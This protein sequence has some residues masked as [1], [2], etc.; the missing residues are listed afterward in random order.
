MPR[1]EH[2]SK[3]STYF[4]LV[5]FDK[6]LDCLLDDMSGYVAVGDVNTKKF[7]ILR[8]NSMLEMARNLPHDGVYL[9]HLIFSNKFNLLFHFLKDIVRIEGVKGKDLTNF[10]TFTTK[11]YTIRN[12][13]LIC[14]TYK[15]ESIEEAINFITSIMETIDI[16][17]CEYSYVHIANLLMRQQ[18]PLAFNDM[19]QLTRKC[20]SFDLD[21]YNYITKATSKPNTA[22]CRKDYFVD[23]V[24]SYDMKSAYPYLYSTLSF[25]MGRPKKVDNPIEEQLIGKFDAEIVLKHYPVPKYRGIPD[26]ESKTMTVNELSFI[27]L[28]ENYDDTEIEKINSLWIYNS[29]SKLP[30]SYRC[31]LEE[32][33]NMKEKTK[34]KNIKTGL[35]G[36]IGKACQKIKYLTKLDTNGNKIEQTMTKQDLNG[37]KS[38]YGVPQWSSRVYAAMQLI[39]YTTIRKLND[40]GCEVVYVDTDC[41]KFTGRQGC[42]IFHELNRGKQPGQMGWWKFE[43]QYE[44]FKA[45]SL[46]NYGYQQNGKTHFV[47]SGVDKH[48][49]YTEYENRPLKSLHREDIVFEK[50]RLVVHYSDKRVR[51]EWE[52]WNIEDAA[53]RKEIEQGVTT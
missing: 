9:K 46:K 31:V 15:V 53:R 19:N 30:K 14:D 49:A 29:C 45:F 39:L 51:T 23:N 35:N 3:Y 7:T 42:T 44:Y 34:D 28:K 4:A 25:P 6:E 40:V 21:F 26:I 11:R 22:Y 20:Y 27:A 50:V 12:L 37:Y 5:V 48:R 16:M 47:I 36:Q 38:R 24:Y 2:H 10:Y 52:N 33:F 32:S 43:G 41:I 18:Y 8:F 17:K 1:M 13:D